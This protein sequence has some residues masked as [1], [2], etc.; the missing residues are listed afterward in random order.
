[1]SA[2]PIEYE[3]L[4]LAES[5][6]LQDRGRL[7]A[8]LA[9][10]HARQQA[11]PA[12]HGGMSIEQFIILLTGAVAIWLMQ[13]SDA[14]TRQWACLFGLVGQPFWIWSTFKAQQWG[15]CLLSWIYAAA[16]IKGALQWV[17]P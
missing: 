9:G 10:R 16:W 4:Q 8:H 17:W 2:A 5:D 15:M 7:A 11:V 13:S 3:N 1:M 14:E 6:P 12:S